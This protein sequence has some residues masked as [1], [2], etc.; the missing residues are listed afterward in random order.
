MVVKTFGLKYELNQ[1]PRFIDE[2]DLCKVS[3]APRFDINNIEQ[4]NETGDNEKYKTH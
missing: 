4:V 3:I 2:V 1:I